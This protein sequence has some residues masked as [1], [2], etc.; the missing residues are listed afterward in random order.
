MSGNC[1]SLK[2]N[3]KRPSTAKTPPHHTRWS[4]PR[5]SPPRCE[6]QF[7]F[8]FLWELTTKI[9]LQL[10]IKS[11]VSLLYHF[12]CFRRLGRGGPEI[13]K[14][15]RPRLTSKLRCV[16]AGGKVMKKKRE[17]TLKWRSGAGAVI[18]LFSS[19]LQ[20][21]FFHLEV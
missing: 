19:H 18:N 21:V 14:S 20:S 1:G 17:N 16:I 8:S 11:V 7:F 3:I 12:F 5:M 9:V 6:N 13:I 15:F 2:R 10:I 4:F